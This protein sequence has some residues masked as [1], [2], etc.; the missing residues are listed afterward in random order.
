MGGWPRQL[1]RTSWKQ[2][3]WHRTAVYLMINKEV[4]G[5][6]DCRSSSSACLQWT[7]LL[8]SDPASA[9]ST[10][11]WVPSRK[12]KP[13]WISHSNHTQTSCSGSLQKDQAML[14]LG[15]HSPSAVKVEVGSSQLIFLLVSIPCLISP[16]SQGP[17]T[18]RKV[19]RSVVLSFNLLKI[20]SENKTKQNKN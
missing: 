13:F 1:G 12:F 19:W 9:Y 7:Y 20:R 3:L 10:T 18:W 5:G 8:Q 4:R 16:A 14:R 2:K 17:G 6:Q 15:L 11:S